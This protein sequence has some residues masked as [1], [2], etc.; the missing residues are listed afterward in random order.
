MGRAQKLDPKEPVHGAVLE[1]KH[2]DAPTYPEH[3]AGY[4][5]K[6]V[7]RPDRPGTQSITLHLHR[8]DPSV[9]WNK[10][11][12]ETHVR[13]IEV[14]ASHWQPTDEET[15][16][17]L[18]D[19]VK[20]HKEFR[21]GYAPGGESRNRSS[22]STSELDEMHQKHVDSLAS[23]QQALKE[24]LTRIKGKTA[25]VS[26][27]WKRHYGTGDLKPAFGE[28]SKVMTPFTQTIQRKAKLHYDKALVHQAITDPDH[29]VEKVDTRNLESTQP[30]VTRAGVE[31]Y[32]G[33]DYARK[34][35]L[36]SDHSQV[37]NQVPVVYHWDDGHQ[38]LLS[39]HHRATAAF[40]RG[41]PLE[42]KVVQGPWGP[43]RKATL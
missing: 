16:A 13:S 28:A 3:M 29:P 21:D 25:A 7:D 24:H 18:R 17:H 11:L 39:G 8:H 15:T 2:H 10:R 33:D 4:G 43:D 32:M 38:I 19:K 1:V 9:P 14:P 37:G 30:D 23:N 22:L 20:F 6:E 41:E 27:N 26:D 5:E 36:Y 12:K 40:L 42:A 31:H 35:M 34:G